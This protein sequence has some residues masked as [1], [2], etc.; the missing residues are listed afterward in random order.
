[1]SRP[2]SATGAALTRDR[3]LASAREVVAERGWAAATSRAIADHAGVNLA[4]INYHFRSKD[5][6]LIA[7]LD[8]AMLELSDAEAP[9]PRVAWAGLRK[10]ALEFIDVHGES[11]QI[12]VLFEATLHAGRDPELAA[13][14]RVHL[15][16]FRH[17]AAHAV[18][19]AAKQGAFA[20]GTD[21]K[22][23][24]VAVAA[25][26]DGL[27]LHRM[28]DP[29]TDIAAALRTALDAWTTPSA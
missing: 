23:L 27:I 13:A 11:P 12:R 16:A 22:S 5:Q 9:P 17:F 4:L 21:P 18:E 20:P 2:R 6:L 1:M 10:L 28:I 25:L 15:D 29:Q 24:G 3:L 7:A 8:R 26:L 19:S 14:V